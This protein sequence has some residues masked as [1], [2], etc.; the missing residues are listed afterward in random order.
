VPELV[1]VGTGDATVFT[2]GRRIDGTWTRP[3]L[4]S[5]ATLTDDDGQ[6]IELTPG[7]TWIQL[8]TAG[9][10]AAG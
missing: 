3:T 8:V 1:F 7:Q 6:A 4:S 10:G 2:E 5:V 9:A